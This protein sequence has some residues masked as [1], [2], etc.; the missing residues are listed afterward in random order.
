MDDDPRRWPN[1][2]QEVI[3]R[4]NRLGRPAHSVHQ[5]CCAIYSSRVS[6]RCCDG[7][8]RAAWVP[9][10][11]N[12]RGPVALYACLG[13]SRVFMAD[14]HIAFHRDQTPVS[15]RRPNGCPTRH[16]SGRGPA[17]ARRFRASVR[18]AKMSLGFGTRTGRAAECQIRWTDAT[19]RRKT[20]RPR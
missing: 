4:R 2:R 7:R 17:P 19:P 5:R 10:G 1:R 8:S 15:S 6:G 20:R 9:A 16:S 11:R 18:G 12:A 3:C 14:A 13:P